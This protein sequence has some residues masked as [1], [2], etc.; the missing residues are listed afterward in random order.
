MS[1]VPPNALHRAS[2][3]SPR[4]DRSRLQTMLMGS[5]RPAPVSRFGSTSSEHHPHC[6]GRTPGTSV[7]VLLSWLLL[8]KSWILQHAFF[9]KTLLILRS[10]QRIMFFS[11]RR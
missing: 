1:A 10:Q 8:L 4:E 3:I 7:A 6:P 2:C 9:G 5:G 11:L